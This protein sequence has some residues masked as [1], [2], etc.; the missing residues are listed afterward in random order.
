MIQLIK[1]AFDDDR[2]S[3]KKNYE[4]TA[5]GVICQIQI[6]TSIVSDFCSLLGTLLLSMRCYDVMSRQKFFYKKNVKILS[7]VIIIGIS[8]VFSLVMLFIDKSITSESITYKYDR[9][10]RCSYWCWLCHTTSIICYSFY[11]LAVI[12]NIYYA[13]KTGCLMING[14]K[15]FLEQSLIFTQKD[16]GIYLENNNDNNGYSTEDKKKIEEFKIMKLK[17]IIYPLITNSIWIFS[18]IYRM[19]D[20]IIMEK[21]DNIE[22]PNDGPS[23]ALE[24]LK[25]LLIFLGIIY[26]FVEKVFI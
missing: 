14:Q 6:V 10:D 23:T 19:T 11:A 9:R 8:I 7:F 15:R 17:C 16:N 2:S 12:L 21:Y 25:K 26:I 13:C 18:T 1:Y 3:D 20:D 4:V 5:R 22:G 24:P